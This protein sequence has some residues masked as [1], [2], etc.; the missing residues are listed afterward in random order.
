LSDAYIDREQTK[1]KH[2]I[3]RGYLQ[4]LAF[5]VL[6]FSDLAYVDGFSGPWE[7]AT[8][9]FSDT[10]FMIAIQVLMDAQE[11][12]AVRDG[13]RP[14]VQ[15]FFAEKDRSAYK[16]LAS[17]VAQYHRPDLKFEIQTYC[18]EFEA[19]I[20]KIEQFIG[21]SFPIIFVDAKGWTGFSFD[22]LAPLLSRPKCEVLVNFMYDFINR[23]V[24]MADE[25]TIASLDPIL[26]GSG[27]QQRLDPRLPKGRA[28]EKLFRAALRE[29]GDFE[30]V[31]STR[32]DRSTADRPHYF[33]VY[34]TKDDR[35]L[36]A[37]R[38]IEFQALRGHA[39]DRADAKERRRVQK[40]KTGELFSGFDADV[41]EEFVTRLVSEQAALASEELREAL[42]EYGPHHFR[43]IWVPLL[44]GY[45]LRVTNVKDVCCDLAEAG[46][47][48]NTWKAFGRRKPDDY[49]LIGLRVYPPGKKHS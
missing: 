48:E 42:S 21:R 9:D 24:H 31:I 18:G 22:K 25:K 19:S 39:R 2:F 7:A 28:V 8:D 16:R 35:G 34:G 13:H 30:H 6:T 40:S 4:E 38:E 41:Q 43:K 1:A 36:K 49:D 5:K 32:I 23:A 12:I 26:G 45:M 3:L 44:R 11:K 46:V 14:K 27:W 15:C 10:S 47:I 33:I 17:A 20:P 29:A 37:F